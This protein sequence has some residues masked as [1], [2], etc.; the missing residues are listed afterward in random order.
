VAGSHELPQETPQHR[1]VAG[2][3]DLTGSV[4]RDGRYYAFTNWQSSQLGIKD[5]GSGEDRYIVTP[6]SDQEYPY[7]PK[8][9]PDGRRIAYVWSNAGGSSELRVVNVDGSGVRTIYRDWLPPH[10]W[11]PDG[12]HILTIVDGSVA[13][14]SVADGTVTELAAIDW[15]SSMEMRFSPDGRYIAYDALVEEDSPRRDIFVLAVETGKEITLVEDP[16]IAR[17]LDWTPDGTRVLFDSDRGMEPGSGRR[18]WLVE[19]TDGVAAGSPTLVRPELQVVR[20]LG[21]NRA[22]SYHYCCGPATGDPSSGLYVADFDPATGELQTPRLT[23]AG[24]GGA[25]DWSPDGRYLAYAYHSRPFPSTLGIRA[26]ESGEEH[27][28]P[29]TIRRNRQFPLQWSPDGEWLLAEARDHRDRLAVYRIDA[30]TGRAM[31]VVQE[32]GASWPAWLHDGRVGYVLPDDSDDSQRIVVRDLG[33]GEDRELC[34]VPAPAHLSQLAVSPDDRWLALLWS[35]VPSWWEERGEWALKIVPIAG[36]APRD[37]ARLSVQ[38]RDSLSRSLRPSVAWT[39]DAQ[40]VLY[41]ITTVAERGATTVLW[42]VPAAGGDAHQAVISLP[43]FGVSGMSMHPSG[44]QIA[45]TG[46]YQREVREIGETGEDM[47][48]LENFLPPPE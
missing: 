48:V 5:L 29:L 13:V 7:A 23:S 47:W 18:A 15:R 45:F 31:P 35:D 46:E 2:L 34:R 43:G 6:E 21:F 36:G 14:I 4:S 8:F 22:G 16:A 10:D 27:R 44:R 42:R 41:T 39:S 33:T 20:G 17:V 37:L 28:V 26:A 11:S 9:A 24:V 3:R 30:Q 1:K 19:V 40:Y 38:G 12:S 25:V 32:P